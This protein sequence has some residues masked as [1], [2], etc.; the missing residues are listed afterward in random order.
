M[1]HPQSCPHPESCTLRYVEHLRGFAVG[2]DALP[3]R[4]VT[5][6][7]GMPD[8]PS[9]VTRAREKAMERDLP[10]YK[11]LRGQGYHPRSIRG[12][13]KLSATAQTDGQIEGRF[14]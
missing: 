12:A 3:T 4:A 9:S 13:D 8:E 2:V 10:A 11:A 1:S 6:N 5:R 14:V 7:R